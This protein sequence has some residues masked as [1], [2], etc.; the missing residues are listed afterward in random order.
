MCIC[1]LSWRYLGKDWKLIIHLQAKTKAGYQTVG[2]RRP[3]FLFLQILTQENWNLVMYDGMRTTNKWAALYF[4]ALM[5]IGYYVLFNLLV[6][7]LVEG[8]TNTGVRSRN[9]CI[10]VSVC[11]LTFKIPISL[12]LSASSAGSNQIGLGK[13]EAVVWGEHKFLFKNW[14][15]AVQVEV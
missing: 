12:L 6:A 7:I 5:A 14:K 2:T 10:N 4:T 3:F 8:F 1:N 15:S 13:Y 11:M 9:H